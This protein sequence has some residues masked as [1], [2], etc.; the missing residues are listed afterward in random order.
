MGSVYEGEHTA[1][2]RKVA[3]KL[4]HLRSPVHAE[5]EQRFE[6][7]ARIAS[8]VKSKHIVQVFDAGRDILLGPFIAMELLEGEDL[9]TYLAHEGKLAPRKACEAVYQAARGLEKAHAANI[10]HRDLKPANLFLVNSDEDEFL[11]KVLDFGIA[12]LFEDQDSLKLT[13]EG[14]TVGTPL[15]MSPEQ[16]RGM[17]HID[18]RTDIYSLGAVLY[19][20]IV[21]KPHVPEVAN[22]NQLVVHI[23]TETAP[24]VSASIPSIDPRIDALVRDMLVGD[25]RDRIQTMREVRER[26]GAILGVV[27]PTQPSITDAGAFAESLGSMAAARTQSERK[28]GPMRVAEE[29]GE[30]GDG[31]EVHFFDRSSIKQAVAAPAKDDAPDSESESVGMFDRASIRLALSIKPDRTSS[32]AHVVDAEA[33]RPPRARPL[34]E[35]APQAAPVPPPRPAPAKGSRRALVMAVLAASAFVTLGSVRMATTPDDARATGA[36]PAAAEL[37]PQA[38]PPAAETATPEV[39]AAAPPAATEVDASPT[40][41]AR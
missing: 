3:L 2:G 27:R 26:L 17:D 29:T 9:E 31:E 34:P 24:R 21:G 5:L 22:Y 16:A 15:Y 33:A 14:S 37:P 30:G 20:A 36:P 41:P 12:K 18:G 38:A 1:T 32:S 35:Q 19:E 28:L 7:E 13:R 11:V 10:A 6:R 40:A 39:P 23:A 8:N 4:V 25:R